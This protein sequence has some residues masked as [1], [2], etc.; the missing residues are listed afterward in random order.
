MPMDKVWTGVRAAAETMEQGD[1]VMVNCKG[2]LD[3]IQGEQWALT[4]RG[5]MTPLEENCMRLYERT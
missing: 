3:G 5:C 1:K 2:G 4:L